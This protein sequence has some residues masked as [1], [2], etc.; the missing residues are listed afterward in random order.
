MKKPVNITR[1][2]KGQ[3]RWSIGKALSEGHKILIPIQQISGLLN[4]SLIQNKG[5]DSP[6]C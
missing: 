3:S 6:G 4:I 1:R 5:Y 2:T